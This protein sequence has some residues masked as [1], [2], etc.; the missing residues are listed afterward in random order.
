MHGDSA[1]QHQMFGPI[2][3]IQGEFGGDGTPGGN[4]IHNEIGQRFAAHRYRYVVLRE[5]GCCISQD[6]M[7]YGYK[8]VGPLFPA[9]DIFYEWK[10]WRTGTGLSRLSE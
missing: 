2:G 4:A 9:S 5:K 6:A 3:E 1:N 10:S 8:D 7:Q